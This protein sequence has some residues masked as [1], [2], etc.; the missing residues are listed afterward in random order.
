[1]AS[2]RASADRELLSQERAATRNSVRAALVAALA[3]LT[4]EDQLVLR[5]RFQDEVRVPRIAQI[6][7]QDAKMLYRR[8]DR[9]REQLRTSLERRGIA[10]AS[11]M[12][13]LGEDSWPDDDEPEGGPLTEKRPQV[14]L[15][16]VRRAAARLAR[17]AVVDW[18]RPT[19]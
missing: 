8:C 9:L 16:L 10:G 19:R 7:G 4:D 6:L 14:R 2:P 11:V 17:A 12:E 18:R 3:E 5:L 15:S 1:M 13:C